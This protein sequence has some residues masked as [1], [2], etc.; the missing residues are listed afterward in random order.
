MPIYKQKGSCQDPKNFRPITIV[1][2]LGKLFTAVLTE[3]LSKFSDEFLIINENQ[4][5]FR[6]DYSTTDNLFTLYA[7]FEL[8]SKKKKKLYCAFIDFEKAFDKVWRE[9][10]WYKLLLNNINGKMLNIIQN[11]YKNIK[12]NIIY[13]NMESDYFPCKNGVRQGENMSPFLFA[14]FINDLETFLETQ[15]NTGLE[16]IS[17]ELD[18][19]LGIYLKIFALLYADDTALMAESPLELQKQLDS[20]YEYCTLWK[21]KVN[22]E[23]TKVVC[24]SKGRLPSNLRFVFDNKELEIVKSFNYL[25]IIL[26]RTGNFNLA[27]KAQADKG[28]KAMYEVLKLS[29][30]HN[31]SISCTF[32]LF[33]KMVKP[34]LLYGSELWGFKNS[35]ILEKV[36]LK[37]CKLVLKLKSST[38]NCFIYGELGR[39][40]LLLDIKGRM[41]S[42]W[43]KLVDGKQTKLCSMMY[44]TMFHLYTNLDVNFQWIDYVKKIL[45]DCGLSNIWISQNFMSESWLKQKIKL[46]LCDQYRQS[47][48][49]DINSSSKALNYRIYKDSI[50][51]EDYFN[52]LSKTDSLILCKFR[53]MNHKLP[54]E[55]GRWRNLERN[56]RK[57]NL[58]NSEIGDEFHYI[59]RCQSFEE[60]RKKYIKP[61]LRRNPNVLSFKEIMAARNKS[62]LI[63]LC[64]FIRIINRRVSPP[65]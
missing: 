52:I 61:T 38:P 35:Y 45:D 4:C 11:M 55:S 26:N 33:D 53:T 44:R 31:L 25:G 60:E 65:D 50:D 8:L 22:V 54:I 2:C 39:F 49:E 57:C 1:S 41:I 40:P 15:H 34:I 59:L 51:F 21:L 7:F 5:G 27:I 17:S 30:A 9:G 43:S 24:F 47:W 48:N 3:R 46:S 12:S 10:L 13:N 28:T 62:N 58:C 36:H 63:N 18:S 23:K 42:Y 32:D 16:T 20:F 37:F 29:N 14:I 56:N 64:R 6:K 19:I